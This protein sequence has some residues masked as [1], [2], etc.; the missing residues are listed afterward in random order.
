LNAVSYRPRSAR[1]WIAAGAGLAGLAGPSALAFF[2]GGYF[3][4]ARAWAGLV[5]WAFAL[6]GLVVAGPLRAVGRPAWVA[7]V[8]LAALS[9][10]TLASITWAP[11]AGNAYG[12]GQIDMLY[13]GGLVA[14]T[15]LLRGPV[16]RA[17]EPALVAGALVVIGYGLSARLLPGVIHLTSSL[18]AEGRLEQPL[19]YWNAMG[20]LAAIA[21]V[22]AARL[23]GD[24][25]R[26]GWLRRLAAAAVAPLGMGLY[27]SFSRGALFAGAAG[28]VALVAIAPRRQA[29]RA[30]ALAVATSVLAGAAAAPFRGVTGLLGRL[31][32]REVQ[33]AVSLALLV[34]IAIGAAFVGVRWVRLPAG[35]AGEGG[36]R[37]VRLPPRA[38]WIALGLVCAGLAAAILLGAKETSK[39]P[40]GANAARLTTFQSDRYEYW[41]VALTAFTSEPLRGVGAGGWAVKWLELRRISAYAVDA[42]SWEL[43]TLAELG[44]VGLALLIALV[45]GVV[46]AAR[47]ALARLPGL[48]AGPVAGL[49]V[50]LAHS[51]LDWDWQLPALTLVAVA[52]AGTVLGLA[53]GSPVLPRADARA[54]GDG[55]PEDDAR[56][57]PPAL[58]EPVRSP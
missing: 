55:D 54:R 5:A 37:A 26:P 52:L 53:G 36:D 1:A 10:W 12:A 29:I 20:E 46:G 31:A 7:I 50:W 18:T 23:A 28:L 57:R 4:T 43:Q 35:A 3:A 16:V 2:S 40:S 45:G 19:S 56:R 48:A 44:L 13:L 27:L 39:L 8:A 24:P 51:P 41:R 49:V 21:L 34:V 15:T 22:L 25:S 9:G 42:H 30:I 14:A 32:T 58:S 38:P 6:I 47:R 11:V 33:G 17:V